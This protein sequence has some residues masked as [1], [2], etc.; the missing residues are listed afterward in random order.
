[1]VRHTYKHQVLFISCTTFSSCELQ[2]IDAKN[3]EDVVL[4]LQD[5]SSQAASDDEWMGM[6][7]KAKEETDLPFE[8][9]ETIAAETEGASNLLNTTD[10]SIIIDLGS[11]SDTSDVLGPN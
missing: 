11:S 4:L 5:H 9:E 10:Y 3:R 7:R 2:A 1:M 8:D 6:N